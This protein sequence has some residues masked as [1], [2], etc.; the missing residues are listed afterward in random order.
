MLSHAEIWSAIDALAARLGTSPSGLAKMGGLDPTSF[1]RSKRLSA[2]TPPRLRWP[3]TESLARVLSAVGVSFGEFASLAEGEGGKGRRGV[4]LIGFAQAGDRGFFDDAGY[5]V[6]EGWDEI[7]IQ[8]GGEGV[9]ALEIAGDSM[10]PVY[11]AGDRI[12]V[13]PTAEPRRGDRVVVKT[14]EGEVM[15]KEVA[16]VSAKRLELLSLNPDY[17]GRSLERKDVAWIAR[18]LWASQ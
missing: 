7:D 18:I 6:G 16:R 13:Q 8:G 1:N 12:L 14:L 11:R 10:L 3:S 17:P 2:E 9:Y 4:P 15:A 5:P